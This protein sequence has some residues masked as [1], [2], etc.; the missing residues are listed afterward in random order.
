MSTRMS[1][2]GST[3]HLL[4]L[5]KE[6]FLFLGVAAFALLPMNVMHTLPNNHEAR[7][8][9]I[10]PIGYAGMQDFNMPTIL[11][12][13]TMRPTLNLLLQNAG[14]FGGNYSS[15]SGRSIF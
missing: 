2:V 15:S 3:K 4:A 13:D 1:F 9:S 7:V 14:F 10:A 12:L 5:W 11:S 8:T 6:L